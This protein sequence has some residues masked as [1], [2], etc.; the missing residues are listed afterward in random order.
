MRGRVEAGKVGGSGKP[1]I[2]GGVVVPFCF[3]NP[4]ACRNDVPW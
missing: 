4:D 3:E 1:V 2:V